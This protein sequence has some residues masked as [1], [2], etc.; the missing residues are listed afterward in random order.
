VRYLQICDGDLSQG[1]MRCDA[2]VSVR[3]MGESELGVRSEIKNINSFRFV[4]LAISYEIERQIDLLESGRS[5]ERDTRLYDAERNETRSMRSK[6]ESNDYRYFPDPDLLPLELDAA[7]IDAVAAELP[8]LPAAKFERYTS[9]LG[10]SEYD[11]AWLTQD[12]AV[13]DY[14]EAVSDVAGN[15]KLAA[16]WVMG[17]LS[18]ALNRAELD[19][20]DSP[21]SAATLGTLLQ[22]IEDGTV[23]G[24]IAKG[25]FETLWQSGGE[26]DAIIEAQGLRQVT[27]AS[28]IAPIIDEIIAAN[29]EQVAQFRAG[30]DKVFGFFVGQVMKATRGK[31]N[32]QQ[33]NELLREALRE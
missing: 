3:P 4:E 1:S 12:P 20:G 23:S 30:K 28:A 29:P 27:D 33:V 32:P 19:I 7:F 11:A 9:T 17:E 6:E 13:A 2:N 24:K 22:R 8:E 5:V 31:A 25:L 21:V 15:A 26:V 18:A 10:M 14:F 16:N